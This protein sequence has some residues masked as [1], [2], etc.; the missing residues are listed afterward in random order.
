MRL[1]SLGCIFLCRLLMTKAALKII[2]RKPNET[3]KFILVDY[4]ELK[5]FE[6]VERF[7]NNKIKS[8]RT[9]GGR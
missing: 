8:L 4:K 3:L 9:E 7:E 5:I 2:H 6:P 1:D